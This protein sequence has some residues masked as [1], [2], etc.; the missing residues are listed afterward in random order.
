[1]FEI[2][3][4][5]TLEVLN[6]P[7]RMRLLHMLAGDPKSVR[8]LAEDLDVP[9]TRLYY[10]VNMLQD[11]GVIAVAETR[12]VGAMI[13]RLYQTVA[14]S[15]QPGQALIDSVND[16]RKAAEIAVATVVDGARLDAEAALERHFDEGRQE[17]ASS[18]GALTRVFVELTRDEV[19]MW[20]TRLADLVSE[21]SE[22]THK[23]RPDT[24]IYSLTMVFAPSVGPVKGRRP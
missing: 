5:E 19:E 7:M 18:L 6:D 11:V 12:K 14:H 3:D 13:Q 15:Y 23:G 20:Q 9:T 21:M 10:H 2:T 22:A 24:E 16:S 8:E 17:M 1:M 4:V